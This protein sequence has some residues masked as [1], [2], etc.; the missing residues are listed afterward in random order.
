MNELLSNQRYFDLA[1][2]WLDGTI[3]PE[4]EQEYA[5]WYNQFSEADEV[6]IPAGIALSKEEYQQKLFQKINQRRVK[7]VSLRTKVA[8]LAVAA[9]VAGIVG[10]GFFLYQTRLQPTTPVVATTQPQSPVQKDVKPG[11][12]GATLILANGNVVVLDTARNGQVAAGA[13]NIFKTNS[14]IS[15]Q[16]AEMAITTGNSINTLS[17]PRA[18]QQQLV[19][20]DGT[21]VWLNA[22]SSIRFPTVFTGRIREVEMTGEAYFEVAKNAAKPFIVNINGARVEVLGTHFNVMAYAN[23]PSLQTTLVEGSVRFSKFGK[24]LLLQPGQQ[25]QLL[26][27]D[28]LK[29]VP[30]ADLNFAMAWKNGKQVLNGADIQTVMRNIERWYDVDVE[31]KGAIPSRTFTGDLP[32]TANLSEIVRLFQINN[33]HATLD[34]AHKK[35][36]VTP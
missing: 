6:L 14:I 19:L 24:E 27:G 28:N 12:N 23:E 34:A 26:Q 5:N 22:E 31:Y 35:L 21:N 11:T 17:T 18:R 9:I 25:S 36:I 32:R 33:I 7:V 13:S 30:H 10:L 15:F 29:L 1:D 16:D 2:K 4:E 8:R 3:S 20:S